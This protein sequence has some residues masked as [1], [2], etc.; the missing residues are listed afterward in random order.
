MRKASIENHY[1]YNPELATKAR[2]NRKNMTMSA[3]CLWKYALSGKKLNGYSFRR[4]RP[5]LNFIADFVCFEIMLIIEVDGIT[6]FNLK[7]IDY[8]RHRDMIL[9]KAGFKVVRIDSFVVLNN[10]N[11]VILDL[12]KYVEEIMD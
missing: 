4:E 2:F 7:Q 1:L 12:E 11:Q 3:S 10:L 8:D 5:I 9:K 6:H